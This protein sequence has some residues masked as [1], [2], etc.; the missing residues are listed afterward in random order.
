VQTDKER[1]QHSEL[2]SSS[3]SS[4]SRPPSL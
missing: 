4:S 2:S 1:T 3:S